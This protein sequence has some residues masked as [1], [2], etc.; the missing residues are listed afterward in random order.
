MPSIEIKMI[1][2]N[3]NKGNHKF[4]DKRQSTEASTEINPILELYD[5]YIK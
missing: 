2:H 4:N 1:H 3:K 5:K